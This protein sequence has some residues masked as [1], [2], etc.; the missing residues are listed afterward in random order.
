MT[1]RRTTKTY[2]PR[3]LLPQTTRLLPLIQPRDKE[4]DCVRILRDEFGGCAERKLLCSKV[5][6][7]LGVT[8]NYANVK[9][10]RAIEKGLLNYDKTLVSL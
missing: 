10:S 5:E 7:V 9:I 6:E 8:A 4:D 1:F 3:V 2:S